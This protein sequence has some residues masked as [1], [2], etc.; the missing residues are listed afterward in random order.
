MRLSYKYS[1]EINGNQIKTD[2]AQN[3]ERNRL[4]YTFFRGRKLQAIRY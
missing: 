2:Y 3:H 4:N 1:K